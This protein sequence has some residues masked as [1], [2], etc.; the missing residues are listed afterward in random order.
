M[1]I[2]PLSNPHFVMGAAVSGSTSDIKHIF[3]PIP[4]HTPVMNNLKAA[5]SKVIGRRNWMVMSHVYYR[6]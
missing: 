6:S 3:F 4:F 1:E 5:T 2:R